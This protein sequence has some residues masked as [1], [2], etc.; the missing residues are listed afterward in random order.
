M[1]VA[2]ATDGKHVSGHFGHCE[3]YQVYTI[4]NKEI[5]NSEFVPNP[6][7]KPGFLPVFLKDQGIDI[8]I[9]GN[10]GGRAQDL[11]NEQGIQVIVGTNGDKELVI[12][13]YL[14]GTLKSKNVVC[15]E[16]QHEGN[17]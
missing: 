14:D 9:A 4:E 13:S 1:K 5:N 6:G 16:H 8:I 10:M 7:H 3:G 15:S 2:I 12:K 11:F 17:C